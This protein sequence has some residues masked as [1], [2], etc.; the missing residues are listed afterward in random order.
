MAEN[1]YIVGT[2]HDLQC[3]VNATKDAVLAFKEE[4]LRICAHYQIEQLFEE[5]TIEGLAERNVQSTVCQQLD[6]DIPIS[7]VDMSGN[8]RMS[9]SL[10]DSNAASWLFRLNATSERTTTLREIFHAVVGEVRERV[11]VARILAKGKYPVLL[12]CGATH[13]K[14]VCDI[15]KRLEVKTRILH[16]DYGV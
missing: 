16:Y 13:A 7:H 14:S 10:T 5:M 6:I 4:I 1:V 11:W 3:G 2:G 8:E 12:I 9:L 15:L